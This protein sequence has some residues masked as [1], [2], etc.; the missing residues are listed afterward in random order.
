MSKKN[1]KSK[2]PDK[3]IVFAIISIIALGVISLL[4]VLFADCRWVTAN[5][6]SVWGGILSA[7]AT[8]LL[9]LIA[10]WQNI[11]YKKQNDITE[12]RIFKLQAFSSCPY[13]SI[14]YCDVQTN[15]KNEFGY[16]VNL[17]NI[18]KTL[19]TFVMI[20]E[21]EFSDRSYY[22]G[23]TSDGV[24]NK[25]FDKTHINIA[26]QKTIEFIS[27]KIEYNLSDD[28]IYYGHIVLSVVGDNQVQ[29]EQ[30]LTIKFKYS[31]NELKF[32]EELSSQF[33][34]MYDI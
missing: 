27:G 31:N 32:I 12:K 26:T 21:I 13:F 3:F 18:G 30:Q 23:K 29:F 24:F 10:V 5:M 25:S 11:E 20:T 19:A 6:A 16:L 22:V 4:S 17:K 14:D 2:K 28:R 34:K 15:N 8:V 33:L 1:N 9:G 7:I